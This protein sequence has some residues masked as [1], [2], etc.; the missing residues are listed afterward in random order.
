LPDGA[1]VFFSDKLLMKGV[2]GERAEAGPKS[3]LRLKDIQDTVNA[4]LLFFCWNKRGKGRG[5]INDAKGRSSL[6]SVS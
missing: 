5:T 1:L 6:P 3:E 2:T 4:R